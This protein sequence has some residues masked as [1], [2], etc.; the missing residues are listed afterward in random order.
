MRIHPLLLTLWLWLVFG[1]LGR[2]QTHGWLEDFDA[3]AA[4]AREERKHLL[5]A[6]VG[7]DW[8][9]PSQR[10]RSEV[11]DAPAFLGA[12]E[13][14]FVP[15]RLDFPYG[16]AAKDRVPHF[17]RNRELQLAFDIRVFPA[18][19]A[20]TPDGRAYADSAWRPGDVR[21][22]LE[23]LEP[24]LAA[25]RAALERIESLERALAAASDT[26][27]RLRV[28]EAAIDS[29]ASFEPAGPV[30][31]R[32]LPPQI[33]LVRRAFGEDPSGVQGLAGRALELCL[34][35]DQ[36]GEDIWQAAL[37][38]DP[39]GLAGQQERALRNEFKAARERSKA[40]EFVQRLATTLR[41]GGEWQRP[42]ELAEL[43]AQ[44][45]F[46]CA[47]PELLADPA[48]AREL[49]ARALALAPEQAQR[50]GVP[51]LLERL[52]G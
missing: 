19:L 47:D 33:A 39:Q 50:L 2:A 45:A 29:L 36:F 28:I 6:F 41:R 24:R 49:G 37:R 4:L 10:L 21:G 46:W 51:G 48:L 11:L 15:V 40:R 9:A 25:G 31:G 13:G 26:A 32:L 18:L 44:A 12:L 17:A 8:S 35:L 52:G 38:F 27:G 1:A 5:V 14:R 16:A 22:Q 34:S 42:A 3:A 30:S 43:A 20:M 23:F 7:S